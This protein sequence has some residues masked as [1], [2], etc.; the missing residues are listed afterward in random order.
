L[1]RFAF[2]YQGPLLALFCHD[3]PIL[4]SRG[5]SGSLLRDPFLKLGRAKVHMEGL[6]DLIHRWL[7]D[8]PC[9]VEP[10]LNPQTGEVIVYAEPTRE[11]P[12]EEWSVIIG[13]IIHNLRSALDQLVWAL[14]V[15]YQ[16]TPPLNPIPKR[17]PGSDWRIIG[18]PICI[19]PHPLDG[20]GNVI[21][22]HVAKDLKSL[23]G[24]RPSLRAEFQGLQPFNHGQN[25]AKKPLAV[26]NELWNIDK[27]RH[28]PLAVGY[29]GL[30][31]VAYMF[32]KPTIPEFEF[33]IFQKRNPGPFKGRT[34]IGRAKPTV[35]RGSTIYEVYVKP[36]PSFD[37]A[38]EQGPPAYGGR[39]LETLSDIHEEVLNILN[40]FDVL[41]GA[42]VPHS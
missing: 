38:F 10:Q 35:M 27:H 8:D 24:V 21:S 5:M 30:N 39:V 34:E 11:P 7:Q 6:Y 3:S 28:L 31:D 40:L 13:D 23:W 29:F 26:L 33:S 22:W 32:P 36:L 9:K 19:K 37:I 25:A 15:A 14:T 20:S 17:G 16:S 1:A 12:V 4:L 41:T 2:S 18:F 42:P